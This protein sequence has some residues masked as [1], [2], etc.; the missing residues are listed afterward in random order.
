M[1]KFIKNTIVWL[2]CLVVIALCMMFFGAEKVLGFLIGYAIVKMIRKM[3]FKRR[4]S[5]LC[6][7]KIK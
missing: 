5:N 6:I 1:K 4:K 2:V 3:I 7:I